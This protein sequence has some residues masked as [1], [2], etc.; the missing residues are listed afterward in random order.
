M[1]KELLIWRNDKKKTPGRQQGHPSLTGTTTSWRLDP[2]PS[3]HQVNK[4]GGLP[5]N[6]LTL[7]DTNTH[8]L[9]VRASTSAIRRRLV[10]TRPVITANT[11]IPDRRLLVSGISSIPSHRQYQTPNL[12][13]VPLR[14]PTHPSLQQASNHHQPVRIDQRKQRAEPN[15]QEKGGS[16]LS[17]KKEHRHFSTPPPPQE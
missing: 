8:V 17:K 16:P 13:A 14:L 3:R 12:Y 11:T 2:F 6:R 1:C 4:C 7:A 9:Y 15:L 10:I 5:L